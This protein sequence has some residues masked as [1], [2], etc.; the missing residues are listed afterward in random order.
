[1]ML[2]CGIKIDTDVE[3]KGWIY[4]VIVGC[5]GV[6]TSKN[7]FANHPQVIEDI[8][9]H[10]IAFKKGY[11]LQVFTSVYSQD[12]KIIENFKRYKDVELNIFVEAD[13]WR[14]DFWP[15]SEYEPYDPYKDAL[16]YALMGA[17]R[18]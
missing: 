16:C 15:E 17:L 3:N 11:N 9:H 7:R 14:V 4:L 18:R 1:M 12:K 6:I 5:F 10:I 2:Y 13:M 8:Y